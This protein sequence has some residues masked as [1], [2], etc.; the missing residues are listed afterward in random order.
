MQGTDES[1]DGAGCWFSPRQIRKRCSIG[2]NSLAFTF[3][4][5]TQRVIEPPD[6]FVGAAGPD[7]LEGSS[8]RELL[9]LLFRLVGEGRTV[10]EA[11]PVSPVSPLTPVEHSHR[12][13]PAWDKEA[14]LRFSQ[15]GLRSGH[16]RGKPVVGG[17]VSRV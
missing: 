9:P 12:T 6:V 4:G 7:G 13:P 10:V 14:A 11:P 3:G 2:G 17:L 8:D 1:V 15:S 16:M 5:Q